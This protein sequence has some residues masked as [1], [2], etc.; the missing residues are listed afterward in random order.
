[1]NRTRVAECRTTL[2]AVAQG[3]QYAAPQQ[4]YRTVGLATRCA[5]AL[6]LCL[7][8][9]PTNGQ[10]PLTC[11][12][13]DTPADIPPCGAS[14]SLGPQPDP[15]IDTGISNPIHRFSGEKFLRDLDL[16]EPMHANHPAFIRLYRSG[17]RHAGPWGAGWALEYDIALEQAAT[18]YTLALADGRQIH[19]NRQGRADRY[20]DGRILLEKPGSLDAR[21]L[22]PAESQRPDAHRWWQGPDGQ[23]LGFDQ[24]GRLASVYRPGRPALFIQ[25]YVNGPF[26]GLIQHLHQGRGRLSLSYTLY[27]DQPLLQA[28]DSPLGRFIYHYTALPENR[29]AGDWRLTQVQ[30]P[31]GMQRHY[32]YEPAHQSGHA[33][34][35][36]GIMIRSPNGDDWQARHWSYDVLG[37]V[38]AAYPGNRDPHAPRLS[39]HYPAD[40]A[41]A[42]LQWHHVPRP[43][44]TGKLRGLQIQRQTDGRIRQ[45]HEPHGGWPDLVLNYNATGQRHSWSDALTGQTR[46]LRDAQGRLQAI[47][48]ANGDRLEIRLDA[49]GRPIHLRHHS[50]GHT[51]IPVDIQWRGRQ[52][53]RLTHP[54]ESEYLHM[55]EQGRLQTHSVRRPHPAGTL[56]YQE[57]FA[58]DAAG[59]LLRHDLPEGGALQ[60]RW[61]A[62]GR[63]QSIVWTEANG[64]QQ[65]VIDTEPGLAGYRYGNGLH[66]QARAD[67]A[68][69]TDTLMLSRDLHILWGEHRRYD[70]HGRVVRRLLLHENRGIQAEHLAHDAEGR[71]IGIQNQPASPPHWLG[72]SA[73]GSLAKQRRPRGRDDEPTMTRDPAGL[74][75]SIGARSLRYQAQR[76]L[77]AIHDD[78]ETLVRYTY[79][80]RGQQIRQHSRNQEIERYYLDNRLVARWIRPTTAAGAQPR[81]GVSE[82]YIYALDTPV[83]RLR[84]DA[85][86]RTQLEFIHSDLRGA[87]V[88]VTDMQQSVRW[89]AD[90]DPFGR[91]VRQTGDNPLV[92]R[93]IGQDEDPVTGWHDNIFRTYLPQK[94]QYLEPDPLGPLP[95]LQA[96]GYAAQQP[97]RYHDP[98][99]LILLAFDGTRYGRANQS[100]VWKLT[101]AYDG[102]QSYYQAGPGNNL[103]LDW[104]AV[105]AASSGQILRNQWQS[106][107]NA[108]QNAQ[109]AGEPTPIDILGY[110]RGA[111]LARDFANRIA[112]QTRQGWFSY[113]DPLRG[114]IGLCVDL[115]FLGLFDTVAQFGLLGAGNAGYDLSI[116]DAW[117][118]VAH[119]VATHEMRSLFPLISATMG[120]TA[121]TI[122]RPF[123]GAHADIG[124]GVLL[125]QNGQTT[126][127]GDLPDVALNWMRWQALAALVPMKTLDAEDQRVSNPLLHDGRSPIQRLLDSDR[128]IQD[129]HARSQGL[130]GEDPVLGAAQRE[131][132]ETF[133]QRISHWELNA[134]SLVGRVDM[135]G[136]NAWLNEQPEVVSQPTAPPDR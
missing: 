42:Q 70:T 31:D 19:F 134:G 77:A 88:L 103:Y 32:Q 102:G 16:P 11:P 79:N 97:L 85:H 68:G 13:P 66:L 34:A 37:R 62:E 133:I 108:L 98:L 2:A 39:L 90:I 46:V 33:H 101:Q 21:P 110:S 71:L 45:L 9:R 75:R 3:R 106:L 72:W 28:L 107:L 129:A 59:R 132:F 58:Y 87:P 81:F 38:T 54:A 67:D 89:A 61:Q 5:V 117:S 123:I 55:N 7:P 115:R 125:E 24:R 1:M 4:H 100:N 92:L 127:S 86:G 78:Q 41:T 83:G 44:F 40:S 12:V 36:T 27:G 51:D 76:R 20:L 112:R 124:G 18:G 22:Y 131:L 118:R 29:A 17:A 126:A 130:Q 8:F 53:S 94:G 47:Q 48:Y 43:P 119:A 35:I 93:L 122:E 6:I 135:E 95:G 121:P 128:E 26:Q 84:T 10:A 23:A 69:R 116:S 25:R 111:A 65:T 114:T 30:R 105:T 73:N 74:P 104:D 50:P 136:Y 113:D 60:Y 120:S 52:P 49:V 57:Q 109:G 15:S 14:S 96:L 99:G 91:L 56:A 80:A 64:R 82:R 63:L